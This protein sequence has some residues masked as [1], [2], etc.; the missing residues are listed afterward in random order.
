MGPC[1]RFAESAY[2]SDQ[3]K[4]LFLIGLALA[5]VMSEKPSRFPFLSRY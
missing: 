5:N 1:P 2:A 3:Q 4:G